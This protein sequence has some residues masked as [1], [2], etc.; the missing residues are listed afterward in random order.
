MR[1][2]VVEDDEVL[3]D[4]LCQALDMAGHTVDWLTHGAPARQ[5]LEGDRF[6]VVVLDLALPDCSG[7]SVLHSWRRDGEAVPVLVLTAY[8]GTEDCVAALDRGADDYV[9]KPFVFEELEARLRMLLRRAN[10]HADNELRCGEVRL[11][12]AY[13]RALIAGSPVELSAYEFAVLEALLERPGGT[14]SREQL[15]SRL[16]GWSDGPESNSV[17]VLIHKLRSKIGADHIETVRGL[18]YRVVP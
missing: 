15:A 4:G 10:G 18:G 11:D 2:L 9:A 3:G 12:R 1:I 13:H 6:D 14:I 16:Y 5:A 8:D 17:N 7:L